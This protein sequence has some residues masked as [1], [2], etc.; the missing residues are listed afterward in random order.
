MSDEIGKYLG[1]KMEAALVHR[2]VKNILVWTIRNWEVCR[3]LVQAVTKM[4]Y[5]N[6]ELRIARR[7][8]WVCNVTASAN[9]G[10]GNRNVNLL[11]QK[12]K[13]TIVGKHRPRSRRV[14]QL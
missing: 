2:K 14:R 8:A 12:E 7:I 3:V 5:T 11:Q 6:A 1:M 4:I 9:K 13:R 10:E